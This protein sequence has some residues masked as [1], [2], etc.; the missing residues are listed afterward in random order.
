MEAT[1]E[2]GSRLRKLATVLYVLESSY[3]SDSHD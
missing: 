2:D 3:D 1:W